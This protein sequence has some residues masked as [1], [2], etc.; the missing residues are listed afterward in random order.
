MTKLVR[1]RKSRDLTDATP[2]LL[3]DQFEF[4]AP[5]WSKRSGRMDPNTLEGAMKALRTTSK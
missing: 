5:L 4:A 1:K 2:R 3:D